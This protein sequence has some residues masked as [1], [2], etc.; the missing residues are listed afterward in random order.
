MSQMNE[1]GKHAQPET[2]ESLKAEICS[3]LNRF[4][5]EAGVTKSD[6]A[7]AVNV[8]PAAVT[9]WLSGE[10][11]IAPDNIKPV[12]DFLG[13]PVHALL[14]EESSF[15][16]VSSEGRKI[17]ELLEQLDAKGQAKLVEYA[18]DL[19]ATGKHVPTT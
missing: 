6:L 14:G 17:L 4:F 18:E 12:C 13:V 9:K 10:S 8:T 15:T 3:N 2:M 19:V 1:I 5:E 7:R 16:E 11:S